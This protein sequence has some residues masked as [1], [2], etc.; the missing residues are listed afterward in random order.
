MKILGSRGKMEGYTYD[1]S[2]RGGILLCYITGASLIAEIEGKKEEARAR[3]THNTQRHE[4]VT[5]R[6]CWFTFPPF[7]FLLTH[8]Y[9]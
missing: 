1:V 9:L 7:S 4:M 5:W 8:L 3:E 6:Y 2:Q